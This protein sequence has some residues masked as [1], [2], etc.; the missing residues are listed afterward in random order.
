[1]KKGFKM[2]AISSMLCFSIIFSNQPRVSAEETDT[3]E[4]ALKAYENILVNNPYEDYDGGGFTA[5][6]FNVLDING[7]NIPELVINGEA[8]NIFT[9][10][11]GQAVFLY[12]S[13]VLCSM[14]Y[15]EKSHNL[16]YY[17]SWKG[18]KDYTIYA[19]NENGKELKELKSLTY[20][21]KK[22]YVVKDGKKTK[23]TK[24]SFDKCL[25]KYMPGKVKLDTPYENT[26][27]NR[28]TYLK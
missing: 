11:D 16:M 25:K 24:A 26:E 14:Y 19:F 13:W 17:Y 28:S 7:D 23:I 9:Y 27:A 22:Y 2:L 20:S 10:K 6:T 3:K 4:N 12:N 15:S 1:M 21:D 18:D 8:P 5:K